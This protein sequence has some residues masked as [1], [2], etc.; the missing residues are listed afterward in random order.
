MKTLKKAALLWLMAAVTVCCL[1][2]DINGIAYAVTDEEVTEETPSQ[3]GSEEEPSEPDDTESEEPSEPSDDEK[4]EPPESSGDSEYDTQTKPSDKDDNTSSS[5]SGS[6]EKSDKTR[7]NSASAGKT[8]SDSDSSADTRLSELHINCGELI[9]EFSPDQYEY[10]VYVEYD[11]E[12]INCGT[13]A[14]AEDTSLKIRA[15]GPLETDGEDVQKRIFA[16]AENGDYSEYV[17]DVHIVKE[18]ELLIDGYLYTISEPKDIDSLPGDFEAGE[19]EL[20][21]E[22]VKVA[23]NGD[24][25]LK[26]LCYVNADDEKDV[27]WYILK[28]NTGELSAAKIIEF[29]DGAHYLSL[30]SG[31]D[32]VYG[33]YEDTTGYF[34][35]EPKTGEVLLSLNGERETS[36]AKALRGNIAIIIA[37]AV[38]VV[39]CVIFCLATRRKYNS[40]IKKNKGEN[41]RYFRPYLSPD[42]EYTPHENGVDKEIK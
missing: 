29:D 25:S 31:N 19:A 30:S 26:L 2:T 12:P 11:G 18:G 10:K 9:P 6:S 33:T 38:A 17:I 8:H 15:E 27:L 23:K 16:E 37:A 42:V 1:A 5:N 36:E 13:T 3:G 22:L 24:G 7:K 39:I 40:Q 41:N 21:S 28:E 20:D 4:E 35:I 14:R 32:L 34:L